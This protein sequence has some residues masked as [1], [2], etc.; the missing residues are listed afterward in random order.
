MLWWPDKLKGHLDATAD[1]ENE[2]KGL[3]SLQ[4]ATLLHLHG[5]FP[6][7]EAYFVGENPKA[8]SLLP[9]IDCIL[10]PVPC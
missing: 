1:T 7:T 9:R 10:L 8:A 5:L 2:S 4:V 3:M 6:E